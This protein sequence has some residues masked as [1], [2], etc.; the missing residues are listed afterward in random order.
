MKKIINIMMILVMLT[1]FFAVP[2]VTKAQ[3]LGDLK[4]ELQNKLDEYNKNQEEKKLT[5]QEINQ[6][7]ADIVA[8]KNKISQTYVEMENIQKE[9]DNLLEQIASKKAQIKQIVNFIQVSNGESAYLEYAFGAESF[10][11]LIYRTAVAEQLAAYNDNLVTEYNT[12]IDESKKKQE[13]IQK[14]QVELSDYQRTL[15][16]K[17]ASL[18]ESLENIESVGLDINDAI[19]YQKEIIELYESKGCKDNE[20]IATCGRK[21]LPRGTAFYRPTQTG[22]ITSEWG[23]RSLLGRTWHEGIDI[24]VSEGTTVYAIANGMVATVVRY[25]CGGNM[26]VVHHNINGKTYTSV[27]AHLLSVAVTKGQ[28][29]DRNT[30]V[31]YSGGGST[32]SYDKCTLGAHLHLTVATGLYGIDYYDWLN[33][34]NVK[35]SIN[36]RTVI[37]FPSGLYNPWT[38]RL[39]AY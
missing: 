26:V 25:S 10:T 32:Q 22:K 13:E 9:I 17:V 11:D 7:N 20:N 31:G 33:D 4:E 12:M 39:T 19:E 18:G 35:Y 8:I 14:K 15:E 37:N 30:I 5:E 6:T 38:D 2:D 29:V 23:Y 1:S 28:T 21:T 36:P 24:G 34:L 3:T 27:Y 16:E